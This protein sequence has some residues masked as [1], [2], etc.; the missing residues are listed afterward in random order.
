MR[1]F[2]WIF[3]RII[4]CTL[5]SGGLNLHK[6]KYLFVTRSHSDKVYP[7]DLELLREPV[8]RTRKDALMVYGNEKVGEEIL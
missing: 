1:N 8:S 7:E 3:R 4:I 2:Y 5:V 6:V